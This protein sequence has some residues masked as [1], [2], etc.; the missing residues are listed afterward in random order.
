[1][2]CQDCGSVSKLQKH[3]VSYNPPVLVR[4]CSI[5]H[6]KRHN[7]WGQV[8]ICATVD[9][10]AAQKAKT[11]AQFYGYRGISDL[12]NSLLTKWAE[13]PEKKEIK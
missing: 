5:C 7:R 13:K 9:H 1:M 11:Q 2:S 12:V 10:D 4:L 8:Q 3:H 6:L